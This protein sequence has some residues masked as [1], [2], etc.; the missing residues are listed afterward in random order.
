MMSALKERLWFARFALVHRLSARAQ[1]RWQDKPIWK[2]LLDG[3]GVRPESVRSMDDMR[4]LPVT[5]KKTF[6]G[7]MAEEYVDKTKMAR[8]YWYVTSGT[9]GT[10]FRFLM[11]DHGIDDKYL[12]FGSMRFLWWNGQAFGSIFTSKLARV[13]I[14]G[15][16]SP[17]YFFAP[18]ADYLRDSAQVLEHIRAFTPDILSTYPS[19]LLDMCRLGEAGTELPKPRFILSFGETLLPGARETIRDAFGCDVYDRY[20]LEE[21]GAVGV[22]CRMHD[23]FHI[24][25]ESVI[26]E[27]IG[28]DGMP[29][30]EGAEGKVLATDLFNK[31]MPFI[32]YDTGD[33]GRMTSAPCPCGLR[34]PRLWVEGRYSAFLVIGGRRIHHLE[35]DGAMDGFM[36]TILQYQVVKQ[37]DDRIVAKLIEGP[38]FD[39]LVPVRVQEKLRAL[40]GEGVTIEVKIVQSLPITARGKSRIVLDESL[41]NWD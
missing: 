1:R 11:G 30:P 2:E 27:V 16:Q 22:E 17:R 26:V 18:V 31:N 21:I 33:K 3:G 41:D 13:K 25:T 32:R 4:R 5:S 39:D 6:I 20:G 29:V 35:F 23:G 9:S 36:D 37:A 7:R 19:L 10:P 8:S 34:S 15:P 24:N 38:G 28:D 40:V 12:D 14:R